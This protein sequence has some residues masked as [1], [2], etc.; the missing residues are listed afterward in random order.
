MAATA[1]AQIKVSAPIIHTG[2]C[3]ASAAVALG[4]DRFAVANDED[5]L[6]RVY[7]AG[8][9]GPPMQT[10]NLSPFLQLSRKSRELDL[11]GAARIGDR[12]YW[13]TSHGRNQAGRDEPSRRH[14]FATDIKL[15][16]DNAGLKPVGRPYVHLLQDLI[17]APN[18][19]PFKLAAASRLAPKESGGLNIEGLSATPDGYLLIGFRSPLP[20]GKALLVP[21]LNPEEVVVRGRS[22][23]FGDPILLDLEGRGIREIAWFEDRFLIIGGGT[24]GKSKARLYEWRGGADA[25]THF[26]KVHFEHMNPEGIVFYPDKGW[27]QFLIL[28]DDGGITVAGLRCKDLKN[29][30]QKS[31]RS[32]WVERTESHP[33]GGGDHAK[34]PVQLLPQPAVQAR[35]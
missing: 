1:F 13:I 24:D 27:T 25:P 30:S 20:Q 32:V 18:L 35:Q 5:N 2:M 15:P 22:A 26:G 11:E 23:K 4:P 12:I 8:E 21:L 6:I 31:F 28:S 10:V 33:S 14:F 34:A 19:K 7:R 16:G 3:D 29:S 9:P 17:N